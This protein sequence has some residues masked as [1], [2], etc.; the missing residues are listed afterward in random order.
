[1]ISAMGLAI[2][3]FGL[4]VAYDAVLQNKDTFFVEVCAGLLIAVAGAAIAVKLGLEGVIKTTV[5]ILCVLAIC[6]LHPTPASAATKDDIAK[7]V[8]LMH[9]PASRGKVLHWDDNYDGGAVQIVFVA[10]GKRYTFWHCPADE[11]EAALLSVW[12]RPDGTSGQGTLE[13]FTDHELDGQVDF[14]VGPP[15]GLDS[16]KY[17]G[18]D[19]KGGR[20]GEKNRP[21]WQGL[22]DTAITA[23]LARLK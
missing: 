21:Y 19:G 16:P 14:G 7:V 18:D 17:F 13:T 12:V 5:P 22:Y 6:S 23:A 10:K 20:K 11:Y 15:G 9:A 2:F 8:K 1:M 3:A 4:M